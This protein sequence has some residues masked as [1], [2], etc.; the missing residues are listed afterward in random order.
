MRERL[1]RLR[2]H[3]RWDRNAE[4]RSQ[5]AEVK[6]NPFLLLHSDL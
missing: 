3:R 5:N 2:P 6:A 4:V 1:L